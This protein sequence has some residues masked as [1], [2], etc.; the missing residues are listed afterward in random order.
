MKTGLAFPISEHMVIFES[1]KS[2]L[3]K[4]FKITDWVKLNNKQQLSKEWLHVRVLT[5]W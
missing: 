4:F 1:A 5:D 3:G 2:K